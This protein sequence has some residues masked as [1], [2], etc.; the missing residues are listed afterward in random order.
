ME[1]DWKE[2]TSTLTGWDKSEERGITTT[3]VGVT[4]GTKDRGEDVDVLLEG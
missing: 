1:D 2:G 4:I 3:M